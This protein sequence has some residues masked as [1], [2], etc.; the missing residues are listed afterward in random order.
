M[1]N[2]DEI[3]KIN[4]YSDGG[5][6]P[7]PGKGG[8]GIILSWQGKS[9]EF[10]QGYKLTTNNRME[11][12]GVI[13]GLEKLKTKSVVTVYTDSRYV[14]DGIEKGW[15]EKWR[16]NNWYRNKKERAINVDLWSRLLDLLTKHDVKFN[17][18][19][20]HNGHPENERC[21][22]LATNALKSDNLINDQGFENI[23][24]LSQDGD[25]NT[26]ENNQIRKVIKEGDRCR[27]CDIPVIK[28]TPKNKKLK[29]NQAYYFEYYLYCPNCKRMYMVEEAKKNIDSPSLF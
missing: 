8:Y 28:K 13:T 27:H 25:H 24:S 5:A 12:L 1:N 21:D 17:W 18:V 19:K 10:F 3:P 20:G 9:K 23:A 22:F 26:N 2:W 16:S 7:N 11:L 15:A 4:L 6:E 29:V 14:I